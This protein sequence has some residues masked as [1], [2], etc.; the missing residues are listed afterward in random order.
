MSKYVKI[1]S[2]TFLVLFFFSFLCLRLPLVLASMTPCLSSLKKR[3]MKPGN[4]V[5]L[6]QHHVTFHS[7]KS[8]WD[9]YL[10]LGSN[11]LAKSMVS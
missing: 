6:W 4:V 5:T 8:D 7:Y 11:F 9:A 1:K 10:Y 3:I 2:K